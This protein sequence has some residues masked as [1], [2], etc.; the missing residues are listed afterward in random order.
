M[1]LE[2]KIIL[3]EEQEKLKNLLEQSH[4]HIFITGKAG[5][6]KST[7]LHEF[8]A[9]SK[10][11]IAL[12][13]PTGVAALNIGGQTIHSLFGIKP[14]DII[15]TEELRTNKI[16]KDI[17]AKLDTLII[18][19]ISMVRA[20]LMDAI[21]HI[22]KFS[23]RNNLAFGG[24]Q[25]IMFGDLFQLPPIVRDI[26]TQDFFEEHYGGIYFFNAKV[27]QDTKLNIHNLQTNFRQKN[28]D[29]FKE[30]L[31]AIRNNDIDQRLLS[32]LNE[33]TKFKAQSQSFITLALTNNAVNAINEREL[34]ALSNKEFAYE[35][36]IEG[37]ITPAEY[38]TE[39]TLKLKV[40]AQV[41]FLRNDKE[42]RFVNG[43]IGRVNFL[44]KDCIEVD[45][46]GKIIELKQ[47]KWDK[48]KYSIDPDTGELKQNVISSFKQYP[49]RLAWAITVHKS[50]GQT[51]DQVV[52]DMGFGAFAHGQTYVAL[53][54][55][56]SLDGLYLKRAIRPKDIIV[57]N[58]VIE[59][60]H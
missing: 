11:Q 28:D 41:M 31:N 50:Q 60:L 52:L 2:E 15:N 36:Q 58:K 12:V 34:K 24:V 48:I 4:E 10:K 40:G 33:R 17:L 18:D 51:L 57:D 19:E 43:S 27:W 38:P 20:D 59:F 56:R 47:E 9:F 21:D 7:L 22:L 53:S 25:I 16:T 44:A 8:K 37:K 30:I 29:N 49:L 13:A 46:S 3:N 23:K 35:A 26:S 42:K 1:K 14:T 54:R 45:L 5:T 55:C 6:G 39:K 32:Q